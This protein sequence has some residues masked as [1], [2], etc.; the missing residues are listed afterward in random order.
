MSL[1]EETLSAKASL[2]MP[3]TSCGSAI[4]QQQI[5]RDQINADIEKFLSKGGRIHD[6]TPAPNKVID[7]L[8]SKELTWANQDKDIKRKRAQKAVL[9]RLTVQSPISYM[10]GKNRAKAKGKSGRQNIQEYDRKRGKVY[11]VIIGGTQYGSFDDLKDALAKRDAQREILGME[12][13]HY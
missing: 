2:Q 5:I 9:S 11:A 6:L 3:F 13:A 4:N 12:K 8:E 7:P 1:S 10:D